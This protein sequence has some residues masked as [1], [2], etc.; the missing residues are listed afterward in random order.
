MSKSTFG[1]Y[2]LFAIVSFSCQ[3]VHQ[4]S[5][6]NQENVQIARDEFGVPH[7]FGKSDADVSYGL[8]W[9]HAEDDFETIQK[10]LLAGKALVGRVFGE[11]GAAI[12]FFVHL[13]ETRELAKE[14]YDSSYSPA[15]KKVL[16]GY[17][18]GINDFAYHHP[19]EILYQGAFP[20]TVHDITSAYILSLAQMSG[21]DQAVQKIF[22]GQVDLLSEDPH[23]KGSNAIAIHPSRT[24]SEEAFL[25]I[26]SHQPLEGPVSW[27]EAH[28]RSE[29]GWNMI[30][31]LFPGGAMIFHGVNEH[32]GWAHTVN[33]PD[34][35]DLYQLDI[36]PE[37]PL[38]YQVDGDWLELQERTIWLKVKITDWLTIPVPKKVWKSIF[39]P[40]LIT[41][42]GAFSIKMG[43]LDR[44]GAP[45][46]WWQMNKAQNFS[47]WKE[48]MNSMQLTSFNT[49]YAD[50]YDTIFFVSNALLPKRTAGFD[51]RET[52]SGNTSKTN[53]DEYH[54]FSELP[55]YLN[56]SSG[57]L[58]N[59]NH[60]PFTGSDS[61]DFL[62][63]KGFPSEMNFSTR[64]NNRST[65]FR[66]LMPKTGTLT[67]EDFERIKFDA[68]LPEK[69]AFKT[70]MDALFQLDSTVYPDISKQ[71]K[72]LNEWDK[73]SE[74]A[75]E[76]AAIFAYC[77]YYW[78][79]KLQRMDRAMD[80]PI[81][82]AEAA[83]SIQAAKKHFLK[84]FK[85]DVVPLGEYQKLI[86]GD[87]EM[88]LWGL[89]DVITAMR[90][91]PWENGRRRGI[92]GESYIMMVR[93][94][95]GLPEIQ[96]INVYGASNRPDSPHYA[97][98]MDRFLQRDLKKMSLDSASVMKTA[99]R[100][101]HPGKISIQKNQIK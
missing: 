53:W 95:E 26:N 51:Y 22:S 91:E 54:D 17:A 8:A 74:T 46:Q 25:A 27:Y 47:Q 30:G 18:A 28:L 38:R 100:I 23:P 85:K 44:I 56:P 37:N 32:L 3:R 70:N 33:F 39:G 50:K 72:I 87:R 98:Q 31:G 86:R 40:T 82:E 99:K 13:L 55:Q 19:E 20:V 73:S 15:F 80:G 77:Y 61:V 6:W 71:I 90:S 81:S 57:Y 92:Q 9:A 63:P 62:D 75:S 76:G 42:Q 14:K 24:D 48:A 101:Y 45:E 78:R 93:F 1:I 49:I 41:D 94:G 12:D 16:E 67:W 21:A 88:P 79:D 7:I 89:D 52:V 43:V 34:L 66:E 97:D 96:S 59:T 68:Q 83:E 29:E 65:R 5:D 10:T 69:L 64:E 60:S 35:L 84:H 4:L 36:D 58:F 11:E 2:I